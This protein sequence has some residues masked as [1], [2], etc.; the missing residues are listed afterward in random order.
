VEFLTFL[1]FA[2]LAAFQGF[3]GGD[4]EAARVPSEAQAVADF[5]QRSPHYQV[6]DRRNQPRG[7]T[8]QRVPSGAGV[9]RKRPCRPIYAAKAQARGVGGGRAGL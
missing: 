4:D 8:R 7:P 3:M 9:P 6:L 2:S 1:W 5:D